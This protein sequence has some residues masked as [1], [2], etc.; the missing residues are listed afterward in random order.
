MGTDKARGLIVWAMPETITPDTQLS[1]EPGFVIL[2]ISSSVTKRIPLRTGGLPVGMYER[3][4]KDRHQLLDGYAKLSSR[5]E[6]RIIPD[7]GHGIT[8][9]APDVVCRAISEMITSIRSKQPNFE[10]S[11]ERSR[12]RTLDEQA[13]EK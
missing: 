10:S 9:D 7:V 4:V 12:H 6:V 1:K 5:G 3:L 13:R 2:E 8:V 11:V